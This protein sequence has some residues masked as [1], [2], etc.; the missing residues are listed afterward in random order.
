MT[1]RPI[2]LF[3]RPHPIDVTAAIPDAPPML[4]RWR[5]VVHRVVRAEG[6]ER[7]SPEWWRED[8]DAADDNQVAI[9]TASRAPTAC[10]SGCSAKGFTA[11]SVR[12]GGTC[13]G[14]SHESRHRHPGTAPR[15]IRGYR[16][17]YKRLRLGRSRNACGVSGTTTEPAAV[18]KGTNPCLAM[19]NC[20]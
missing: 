13:T 11:A 3:L 16:H 5:K 15:R 18:G 7:I 2:R 19:P 14:S 20:R 4:F 6:P 12:P 9:I 1:E 10:A 17:R 8:G